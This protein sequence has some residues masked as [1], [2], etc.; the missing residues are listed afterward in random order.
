LVVR[1]L[2]LL[3]LLAACGGSGSPGPAGGGGKPVSF[4]ADLTPEP[5]ATS[6]CAQAGQ[7]SCLFYSGGSG[8]SLY[9]PV[10]GTVTAV[11]LK[12]AA[13]APTGPM[14]IVVLRSLYQN[15][16]GHPGSP[17]FACCFVEEYGPTF[18]P[19]AGGVTTVPASLRMVVDPTPPAD[20]TTTIARGDFLALSILAPNVPIPATSDTAN[21]AWVLYA[22]APAPGNPPAPSP[23]AL[24]NVNNGGFGFHLMMSADITP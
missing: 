2:S 14:Q 16:A 22:P 17:N 8:P 15:V 13:G 23:N 3:L 5:N 4:G 20:D 11:R 24:G 1:K 7:R 19:T 18:T 10:N 12:T 6:T 9:A 21:S